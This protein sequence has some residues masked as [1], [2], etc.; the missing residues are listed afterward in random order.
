M[1]KSKLATLLVLAQIAVHCIDATKTNND[2]A[3]NANLTDLFIEALDLP[4]SLEFPNLPSQLE[5]VFFEPENSLNK[6]G[7]SS[8]ELEIP[9]LGLYLSL[10]EQPENQNQ[11]FG[12]RSML[13]QPGS[14]NQMFGP[15]SMLEQPENQNQMFEP[16]SMLE[17]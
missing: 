15:R 2:S 14:Q 12:P 4:S 10:L 6:S 13:E 8:L 7:N 17:I 3:T 1:M 11:M 16:R 9:S 5:N